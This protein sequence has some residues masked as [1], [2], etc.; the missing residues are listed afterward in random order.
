M[1][2]TLKTVHGWLGFFVMPWIVVI[3]LTGIYLNHSEAIL[4]WLPGPS[5]DERQIETW[6]GARRVDYAG[7]EAIAASVFPED[8]FKPS[9][10]DSYHGF[11]AFILKGDSGRVIVA[12]DS[13]FY[14]VKTRF[15]RKTYDPD[16]RQVDTKIYWGRIFKVLH[17]AGWLDRD[18]LGTWPA[19]IAGG[20]MALFGLTGMLMFLVPRIRRLRNRAARRRQ[21]RAA[22]PRAAAVPCPQ[23]ITLRT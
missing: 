13:G 16:G 4:A 9:S 21:A 3:G 22:A 15:L 11:D 7:A 20:A 12:K 1:I 2:R 10:K 5:F 19:D 17:R 18:T 6:P 8:S 14:W 23:R